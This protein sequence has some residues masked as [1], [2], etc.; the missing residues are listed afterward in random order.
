MVGRNTSHDR[1]QTGA[2]G[3]TI[4]FLQV[5]PERNCSS[6]EIGNSLAREEKKRSKRHAQAK[7]GRGP[8]WE[9]K[10]QECINLRRKRKSKR[11][12]E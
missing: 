1:V 9:R 7:R 3:V 5:K 11:V 12:E 10:P 8:R 6:R 4:R 2:G